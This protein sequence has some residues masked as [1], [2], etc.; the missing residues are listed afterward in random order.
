MYQYQ[1]QQQLQGHPHLLS[2]PLLLCNRL[3]AVM[4]HY[5]ARPT[6][7]DLYPRP[8]AEAPLRNAAKPLTPFFIADI[9]RDGQA[10]SLSPPPVVYGRQVRGRRSPTLRPRRRGTDE[11]RPKTPPSAISRPW[12]DEQ[13]ARRHADEDDDCCDDVIDDV[14]DDDEEIEVDDSARSTKVTTPSRTL[15]HDSTSQSMSVCPLDALLRMTS[16]PFDDPSSPGLTAFSINIV[17][18]NRHFKTFCA[19]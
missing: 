3:P 19:A 9:L 18:T 6:G 14:D 12:D 5:A 1:Q 10:G 11:G 7:R 17:I 16:Q 15:N 13:A 2:R 8:S 4:G